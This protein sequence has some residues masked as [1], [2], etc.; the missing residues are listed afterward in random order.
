M[1]R[2][3]ATIAESAAMK[4]G[5]LGT[6]VTN[7]I[8]DF[9]GSQDAFQ[10]LRGVLLATM[11]GDLLD[12]ERD[13]IA[14]EIIGNVELGL[15]VQVEQIFSAER[16]RWQL[17]QRMARFFETHDLLICPAV[18]IPPFPVD[19]RY[20]DTIDGETLNTYIDWFA[21]TFVL[22]LS[23]CPVLCLPCGLNKDGLPVGLQLVG[24]PRGEERLLAFAAQLEPLLGMADK[25]PIDPLTVNPKP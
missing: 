17:H 16:F 18:S 22:S 10:V 13:R 19:Q 14:P 15:Q 9:A 24:K 5:E 12:Q 2:E 23:A 6:D 3:V 25:L 1:A 8:P 7:D 11:M 21:I 20:V 4:F